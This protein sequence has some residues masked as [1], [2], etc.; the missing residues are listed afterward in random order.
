MQKT[1]KNMNTKNK[2]YS[3][4]IFS[5]LLLHSSRYDTPTVIK[6]TYPLLLLQWQ[7]PKFCL[8]GELPHL[9]KFCYNGDFTPWELLMM[10]LHLLIRNS[11]ADQTQGLYYTCHHKKCNH[12]LF[13]VAL[14]SVAGIKILLQ[15]WTTTPIKILLQRWFY[16]SRVVNGDS[17]PTKILLCWWPISPAKILFQRWFFS[18]RVDNGDSTPIKI[19]LCWWLI[20]P[21][22]ILLQR[23]FYTS[24]VDNG[25]STPTKI[26]LCWWTTTSAKILLQRWF[27]T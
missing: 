7:E 10:T 15:W 21:A 23:W 27:Y 17:T 3:Y 5:V 9:S 18:L 16:T 25:D 13:I 24:R 26:L 20:S 12:Y 8:S 22:K 4:F 14:I 11:L 6:K 19:L 1:D 2:N